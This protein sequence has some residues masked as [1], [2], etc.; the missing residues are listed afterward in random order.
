MCQVLCQAREIQ[1][2]QNRNSLYLLRSYH[3]L[4]DLDLNNL[5]NKYILINVNKNGNRSV[6]TAM[7]NGE[8]LS[9]VAR[10]WPMIFKLKFKG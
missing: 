1:Q 5:T 2:K 8:T 3:L 6:Q 9:E 7:N 4:G 10:G